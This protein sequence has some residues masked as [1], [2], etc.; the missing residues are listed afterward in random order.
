MTE[1]IYIDGPGLVD[2]LTAMTGIDDCPH[3]EAGPAIRI[4]DIDRWD[5]VHLHDIKC[6]ASNYTQRQEQQAA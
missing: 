2:M 6:P 3:C 1:H 5:L 4:Y